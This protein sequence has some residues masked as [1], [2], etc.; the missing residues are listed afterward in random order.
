MATSDLDKRDKATLLFAAI[1]MLLA[2][3][4]AIYVPGTLG[5]RHQSARAQLEQKE[6]E[7]QLA[8]LDLMA[9]QERVQRQE[10]LLAILNARDPRFDLFSYVNAAIKE[11]GLT[12]RAK[13]QIAPTTRSSSPRHPMVELELTSVSLAEVIE[14]FYKVGGS[15]NLIGVHKMTLEPAERE[16]GL[17]CEVTFV[18][19]KV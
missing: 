7:L 12:D 17:Q 4:M 18:T 5:K 9:E 16:K 14:L 8:Q 13:L 2:L 15:N 1:F 11:A 3:F 6:Q 19:L 10:K